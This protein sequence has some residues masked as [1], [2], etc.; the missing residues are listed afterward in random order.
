MQQGERS[1]TFCISKF[2]HWEEMAL[3]TYTFMSHLKKKKERVLVCPYFLRL[4]L[5]TWQCPN[6]LRT[7][8]TEFS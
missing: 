5:G 6:R 2:W 4:S 1:H 7:D 3:T 8:T